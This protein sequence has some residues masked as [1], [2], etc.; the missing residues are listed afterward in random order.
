[1]IALCLAC[2]TTEHGLS[3]YHSAR[4]TQLALFES[5]VLGFMGIDGDLG[6][7]ACMPTPLNVSTN[8]STEVPS[9]RSAPTQKCPH[10]RLWMMCLV[11]APCDSGGLAA[12]LYGCW[13]QCLVCVPVLFPVTSSEGFQEL[14]RRLGGKALYL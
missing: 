7:K 13:L 2:T 5:C 14:S 1:M 6:C 12:T 10:T 9:H 3:T 11:V 4:C 8:L